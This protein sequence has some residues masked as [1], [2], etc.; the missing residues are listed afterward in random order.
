MQLRFQLRQ[1]ENKEV[2]KGLGRNKHEGVWP[3]PCTLTSLRK[4]HTSVR[5]LW[6]GG[7]ANGQGSSQ[8]SRSVCVPPLRPSQPWLP[9]PTSHPPHQRL[10]SFDKH[11]STSR[12]KGLDTTWG[13]LI[14][15]SGVKTHCSPH[16]R[17]QHRRKTE[18]GMSPWCLGGHIHLDLSRCRA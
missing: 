1:E 17:S 11:L 8:H 2:Y 5:Q 9:I 13:K 4:S 10:N 14:T 3:F 6:K 12:Y 18:I 15:F 16:Q 7:G